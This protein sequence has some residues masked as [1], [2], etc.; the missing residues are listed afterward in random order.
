MSEIKSA[1]LLMYYKN[2]NKLKYFLVHPGGP[3]FVKKD[4]GYWGIPKGLPDDNEDLLDA[5][6]REFTEET[7]IEPIAEEFIPLGTVKQSGGKTVYAWAF[8]SKSDEPFE[9]K[10]N[11][12]EIEWPPKS[13][14]KQCFPEVDKGEFYDEDTALEKINPAQIDFIYRLKKYLEIT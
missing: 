9:L 3:Y 8:E 7:G 4:T 6:K 1:G 14:K 2:G 5:A 12:F 11:T 10:C 13:G